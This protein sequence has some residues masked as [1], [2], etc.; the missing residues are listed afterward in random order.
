[1]RVCGVY[2]SSEDSSGS[3]EV[4]VG[5]T[6]DSHRAEMAAE[7]GSTYRGD[8]IEHRGSRTRLRDRSFGPALDG[9]SWRKPRGADKA[10]SFSKEQPEAVR[11]EEQPAVGECYFQSESVSALWP[12]LVAAGGAGGSRVRQG[13]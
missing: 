2:D 10:S 7:F 12:D 13:A 6:A 1:A 3:G 11:G 4:F 9:A 5:A 8:G